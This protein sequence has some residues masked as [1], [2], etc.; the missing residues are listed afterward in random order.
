MFC[1]GAQPQDAYGRWQIVAYQEP[2]VLG[3]PEGPV[4]VEPGDWVFG[5]ADG[6]IVIPEAL[7]KKVCALAEV[8]LAREEVI[9]RELTEAGDITELYERVGRW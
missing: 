3:G 1:R 7:G 2:V 6:V 8:R 4:R 5:D 9:R